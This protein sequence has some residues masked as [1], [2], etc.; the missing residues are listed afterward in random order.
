MTVDDFLRLM[1]TEDD[2]LEYAPEAAVAAVAT[3]TQAV[4]GANDG[5]VQAVRIGIF[6][7]NLIAICKHNE[8]DPVGALQAV[9]TM[10]GHD[11]AAGTPRLQ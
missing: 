4:R 8:I 2:T 3:L 7:G 10:T 11:K 9:M 5:I 6:A 1:K